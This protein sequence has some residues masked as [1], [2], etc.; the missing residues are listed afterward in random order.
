MIEKAK[1][2][3]QNGKTTH[4]NGV[5]YATCCTETKYKDRDLI[6]FQKRPQRDRI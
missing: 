6:K 5:H 3:I 1:L 2:T 4:I